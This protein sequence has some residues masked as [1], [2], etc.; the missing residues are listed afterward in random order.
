MTKMLFYCIIM[1][2]ASSYQAS[3]AKSIRDVPGISRSW[4]TYL[5][6]EGRAIPSG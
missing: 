5:P 3:L 2:E 6:E 1:T 4:Q